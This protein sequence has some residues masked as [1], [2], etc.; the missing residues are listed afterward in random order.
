M[1]GYPALKKENIENLGYSVESVSGTDP[2]SARLPVPGILHEFAF[3]PMTQRDFVHS[4]T[5]REVRKASLEYIRAKLT[6]DYDV[7]DELNAATPNSIVALA[8][9]APPDSNGVIAPLDNLRST[10][11]QMG[12]V[13]YAGGSA[14]EYW[15]MRWGLCDKWTLFWQGTKT[16]RAHAEFLG[17]HDPALDRQATPFAAVPAEYGGSPFLS[18]GG[19]AVSFTGNTLNG[20]IISGSLT[21]DNNV[22]DAPGVH[23]SGSP[24]PDA[25][26]NGDQDIYGALGIMQTDL[27]PSQFLLKD[28][29]AS[30]GRFGLTVTLSKNAA[31][32]F[33]K[34]VLADCSLEGDDPGSPGLSFSR[35]MRPQGLDWRWRAVGPITADVKTP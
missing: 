16:A 15:R 4:P 20:K 32:Q 14:D 13:N 35:E 6:F 22:E 27:Q 34:L 9:G 28:P 29:I 3:T 30:S 18:S 11:W 19:V 24:V 2:L 33:I 10:T 25:M 12:V 7:C 1:P 17:I 31:A 21:V 26:F 8:L 23:G 5:F